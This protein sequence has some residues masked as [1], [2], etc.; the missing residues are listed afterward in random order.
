MPLYRSHRELP[1]TDDNVYAGYPMPNTFY[2]VSRQPTVDF[3]D[4]LRCRELP[5]FPQSLA[6]GYESR[7]PALGPNIPTG[8]TS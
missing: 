6:P 7:L 3:L 2:R 4:L 5:T 8:A 1:A